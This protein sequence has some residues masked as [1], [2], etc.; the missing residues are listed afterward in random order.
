MTLN[1][2]HGIG[3]CALVLLAAAWTSAPLAAQRRGGGPPAAANGE[4]ANFTL[5]QTLGCLAEAAPGRWRLEQATAMA[6]TKDV[7]VPDA[8]RQALSATAAGTLTFRLVSIAPFK[9]DAH[10]G[11]RVLVK[12][13]LNRYPGE[14]PLL[15]VTQLQPVSGTCAP[16]AQ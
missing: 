2:R 10:R 16:A 6:A 4:I 3:C 7:P 11:T 13:I 12:G 14:E 1:V 9:P 5:V 8:E 15:N